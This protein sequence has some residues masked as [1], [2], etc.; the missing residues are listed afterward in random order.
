MLR[1]LEAVEDSHLPRPPTRC[2]LPSADDA[3]LQIVR[4]VADAAAATAAASAATHRNATLWLASQLLLLFGFLVTLVVV[5]V[6]VAI[7]TTA[8]SITS[9]RGCRRTVFIL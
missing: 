8:A 5:V 7:T 1:Y 3:Q 2:R 4:Q 9:F 6:V